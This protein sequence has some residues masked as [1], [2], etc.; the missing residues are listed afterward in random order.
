VLHGFLGS[1]LDWN[2]IVTF[3][4]H[5]FDILTIDL[6]GHG[7]SVNIDSNY[8]FE[9][10]ARA[11]VK[12]LKQENISTCTLLGYSMGGRIALYTTLKYPDRFSQLILESCSPGIQSD[13]ERTSRQQ[14][15][16]NMIKKLEQFCM[17]DFINDWY[18]MSLFDSLR[19]HPHYNEMIKR[20]VHNEASALIHSITNLG[21]GAMPS[22]WN[23]LARLDVPIHFV[24]GELDKKY[25]SIARGIQRQAKNVSLYNIKNSGHNTHLENPSEFST[26]VKNILKE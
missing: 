22:L 9:N 11:I 15:E 10:V 7:Q 26:V 18:S 23:D 5:D 14:F 1:S 6:P 24:Y 8:S 19:A 20:R 12:I 17:A 16:Q 2:H 25:K 13:E 3:L 21:A 4:E